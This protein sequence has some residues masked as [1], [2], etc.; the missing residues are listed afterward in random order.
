M[1]STQADARTRRIR[2]EALAV[3]DTLVFSGRGYRVTGFEPYDGPLDV[4][5]RIVCVEGHGPFISD[6]GTGWTVYA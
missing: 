2:S 5:R 3:G 1:A 6:D 4:I